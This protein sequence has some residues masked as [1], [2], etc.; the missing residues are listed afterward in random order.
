MKIIL[1]NTYNRSFLSSFFEEIAVQLSERGYDIK[2]VSLKEK[3]ELLKTAS[4]LTV[5]ILRKRNKWLNYITIFNL[6]KTEKP[7]V[8][9]SNFSYVNPAILSG[10]LLGVKKNIIWFH[11]LRNQMQFS[12]LTVFTKSIFMNMASA[13]ITNSKE[14][15]DEV[16]KDYR[17]KPKKIYNLPFTTS[18]TA[19]KEESID[20][21]IETGKTYIGCPGRL[22]KD[23]NQK[24]LLDILPMLN[25]ENIILVFAGPDE[26]NVLQSHPNYKNYRGQIVYLGILSREKMI[27]F[28]NAMD[29]IV[30][31]SH[32]EAFGLVFIEAL[33]LGRRTLVSNRFGALDYIKEDML[34]I[35]FDPKN[36]EELTIKIQNLLTSNKDIEYFRGLYDSNFSLE[37]IVSSVNKIIES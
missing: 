19:I 35:S 10:R 14:L 26:E 16:S 34:D 23:K 22:N 11:T 18:V 9:I 5:E 13:I 31:P 12:D 29:L 8:V 2:I 15:M 20:I 21:I 4:G 24:I 37:K 32:N 1:F 33:A 28:Y 30:L 36:P 7:D 6:I 17:Q 25:N 27:G 3:P